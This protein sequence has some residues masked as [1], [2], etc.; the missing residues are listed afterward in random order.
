MDRFIFH[1]FTYKSGGIFTAFTL[2]INIY[3]QKKYRD[4]FRFRRMIFHF[5]RRSGQICDK[6]RA[7]VSRSGDEDARAPS[8]AARRN[9]RDERLVTQ[10]RFAGANSSR[11]SESNDH[12]RSL[13]ADCKPCWNVTGVTPRGRRRYVTINKIALAQLVSSQPFIEHLLHTPTTPT[14]RCLHPLVTSGISYEHALALS[15][16]GWINR[17]I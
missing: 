3:L 16:G 8:S 13:C 1:S 5:S 17:Y 4:F 10:V 9:R 12:P 15:H 14:R 2:S 7:R 6:T 11:R